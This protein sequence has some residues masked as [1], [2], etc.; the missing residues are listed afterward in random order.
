MLLLQQ[1]STFTLVG[2]VLKA[3]SQEKASGKSRNRCGILMRCKVFLDFAP[4]KYTGRIIARISDTMKCIG[5]DSYRLGGAEMD[6][7]AGFGR[8]RS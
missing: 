5:N 3:P 1:H 2:E 6:V 8:D 4:R 7:L